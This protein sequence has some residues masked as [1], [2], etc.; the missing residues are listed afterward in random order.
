MFDTVYYA[1]MANVTIWQE[2]TIKSATFFQLLLLTFSNSSWFLMQ[3]A[4]GATGSATAY[5]QTQQL[6]LHGKGRGVYVLF[7]SSFLR[8]TGSCFTCCIWS[9]PHVCIAELFIF[10]C[11]SEQWFLPFNKIAFDWNSTRW[12]RGGVMIGPTFRM[13]RKCLN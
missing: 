8:L 6:R 5:I 13:K 2:N 12:S 10:V 9:L 11:F 3:I 4:C 1:K 7:L